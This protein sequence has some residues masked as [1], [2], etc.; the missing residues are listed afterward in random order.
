MG[1]GCA[2]QAAELPGEALALP[3]PDLEQRLQRWQGMLSQG[4]SFLEPGSNAAGPVVTRW[5]LRLNQAFQH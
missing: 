1:W 5:R 2:G 4:I 3:I